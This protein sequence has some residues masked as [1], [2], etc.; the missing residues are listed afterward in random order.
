MNFWLHIPVS[1]EHLETNSV[2][3][4]LRNNPVTCALMPV[5]GDLQGEDSRDM[6]SS[7]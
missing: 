3:F 5:S 1:S 4:S 7:F 6:S 2:A